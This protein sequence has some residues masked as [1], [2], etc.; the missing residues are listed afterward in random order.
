MKQIYFFVIFIVLD[1]SLLA[2]NKKKIDIN[3]KKIYFELFAGP[4]YSNQQTINFE[5]QMHE[6][7]PFVRNT[8]H[9]RF[10]YHFGFMSNYRLFP[11]FTSGI[12]FKYQL[13]GGKYSYATIPNSE[14]YK[15]DVIPHAMILFN[16]EYIVSNSIVVNN[17]LTLGSNILREFQP[18]R[19]EVAILTGLKF[20]LTDHF[21]YGIYYNQGLNKLNLIPNIG[22]R[23]FYSFDLSLNF[24]F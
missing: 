22:F 17:I 10:L 18:F 5:D 11:K 2:Q 7:N 8:P 1:C 14:S 13:K 9:Y 4:T 6:T 19:L 16:T 20:K 24:K 15:N 21:Y 12:G 3:N 23:R